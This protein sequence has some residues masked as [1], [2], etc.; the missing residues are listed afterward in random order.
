MNGRFWKL[1]SG[2][3]MAGLLASAVGSLSDDFRMCRSL[4]L[5]ND[6][7]DPPFD[8]P[9]AIHRRHEGHGVRNVGNHVRSGRR[10]GQGQTARRGLS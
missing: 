4:T 7:I 9:V 2:L 6:R 3:T 10:A 5:A 8:A 1:G